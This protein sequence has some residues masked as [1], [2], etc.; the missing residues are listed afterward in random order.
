MAISFPGSPT[1]GQIHTHNTLMWRWDGTSWE[2]IGENDVAGRIAGG[3]TRPASPIQGQVFFNNKTSTMELYDGTEW[4]RVSQ[5][6][7]Q[8]LYRQIITK[9]YVMGGYQNGVPWLNVNSMNHQTDLTVNLGDLL[10]TKGSYSNGGC[11]DV[12]GYIWN[13]NNT[14]STASTTTAGINM[15]TETGLASGTTPTLVY[16]R[17]DV[18]TV[19][20]EREYAYICGGGNSNIDVF[21]F[22]TNTMY[23]AQGLT[24]ATSGGSRQAGMASH[25]GETHGYVWH[26]TNGYQIT[27]AAGVTATVSTDIARSASSQQKGIS[28]KHGVG[29]AGNEGNYLGGYNLR[30]TNY[31]TGLN[32]GTVTKPVGNSGEENFDMGQ[33]HQYMMGMYNGAQNN[34]GWR[35]SYISETGYSLGAGSVRTGPAGGSSGHCVWKATS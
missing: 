20:K 10:H 24:T 30:K 16:S 35:F 15:V 18:G 33:N 6:E 27:F 28:S 12:Y 8:F 21:N 4:R 1:V 25:S 17:N 5:D 11:G 29:Y 31:S 23:G 3:P 2:S 13:A 14:H 34:D 9:S 7:R 19:F 32:A 22:R 26:A